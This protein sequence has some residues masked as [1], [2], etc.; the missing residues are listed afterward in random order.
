MQAQPCHRHVESMMRIASLCAPG[1]HV[2]PYFLYCRYCNLLWCLRCADIVTA[3]CFYHT[4]EEECEWLCP[5]ACIF[6]PPKI[7]SALFSSIPGP[8]LCGHFTEWIDQGYFTDCCGSCCD[9]PFD[10]WIFCVAA[11]VPSRC[12]S[13][14]VFLFLA[15]IFFDE[16]Q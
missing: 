14:L 15:F 16:G 11:G 7:L 8:R 1:V 12:K 4:N 13:V 10:D 5:W 6:V 2:T 9:C 3:C